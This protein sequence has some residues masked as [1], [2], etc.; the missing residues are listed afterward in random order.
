MK[1]SE[2]VDVEVEIE[3]DAHD[4]CEFIESYATKS[5]IKSIIDSI[6]CVCEEEEEITS[7]DKRTIIDDMKTRLLLK[8]HNLMTLDELEEKLGMTYI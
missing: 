3:I 4:V 6:N 5:D 8:A 2:Y 1:K 7:Y